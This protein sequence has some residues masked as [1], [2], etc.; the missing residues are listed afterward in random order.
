METD[1]VEI[2]AVMKVGET[3]GLEAGDEVGRG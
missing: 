1:V 3:D 2:D